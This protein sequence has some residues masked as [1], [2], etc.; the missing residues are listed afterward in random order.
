MSRALVWACSALL[1]VGC[2]RAALS[3]APTAPPI[4]AAAPPPSARTPAP[5]SE[6]ELQDALAAD[7]HDA[8]AYEALA[9]LYYERSLREPA[10]QLLARRVIAQGLAALARDGRV[11]PD[12]L[13][14]RGLLALQDG[15]T[16]RALGDFTVAARQGGDLR[17][18]AAL[19]ATALQ[20][21]DYRRARPAFAFV[22]ASAQGR[23][24]MTAWMGLGMAE[25]GIHRYPEARAA[26]ERASLLAPADP[27]PHYQLGM[28]A[29]R[30]REDPWSRP[31]I[32][33]RHLI[34]ARELAA[35]D[36]RFAAVTAQ[37]DAHVRRIAATVE[38][39]FAYVRA[40]RG[41]K[42]GTPKES[43]HGM[44]IQLGLSAVPYLENALADREGLAHFASDVLID[45]GAV[46][47]VATWCTTTRPTPDSCDD[48][49][50]RAARLYDGP[51]TEAPDPPFL[52][53]KP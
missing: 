46:R 9:R 4:A 38:L 41:G 36:P 1:L 30:A 21:R 34:R 28:L 35:A 39:A 33:D 52:P 53:F 27:R 25:E 23:G 31:D 45:L 17:T 29:L 10:W 49:R 48:L 43:A 14:T 22:V 19:A 26:F 13:T 47:T 16:D 2:S 7:I 15:R 37:L 20:I 6:A 24:D 32:A 44:L 3:P 51:W 5:P 11:S 50:E 40:N 42:C 12:L 8:A 18:Q